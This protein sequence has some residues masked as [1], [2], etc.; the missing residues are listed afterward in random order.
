M[1]YWWLDNNGSSNAYLFIVWDLK[2]SKVNVAETAGTHLCRW[3]EEG[4]VKLMCSTG[5][6]TFLFDAHTTEG[7]M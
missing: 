2:R 3:Y 6:C 7:I 4:F 1:D 5:I